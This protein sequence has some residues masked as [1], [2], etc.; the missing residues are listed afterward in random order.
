MEPICIMAIQEG[1][2]GVISDGGVQWIQAGGGVWHSEGYKRKKDEPAGEWEGSI[3]QLWIQLPSSHEEAEVEYS[4]LEP[5]ALPVI[6]NVKVLTGSYKN[7]KGPLTLPV[8]MTYLDVNLKQGEKWNFDTPS[9]QTTGFVFARDGEL[10]ISGNTL[11]NQLMGILEHNGGQI[12]IS[13]ESDEAQFVVVLAEPS[14]F[15]VIASGGSI[16]T[17]AD[18]MQRSA[19]RIRDRKGLIKK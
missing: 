1:N 13:T 17:N 3:H 12:S 6:E 16:H 9:G 10:I 4:N 7:V 2:H 14:A 5:S 15:P 8:K 19:E 11:P 18:A